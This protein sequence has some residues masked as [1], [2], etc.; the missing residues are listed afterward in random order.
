MSDAERDD[1]G[2]RR[3]RAGAALALAG[4]AARR[5]RH[6]QRDAPAARAEGAA[7]R[8]PGRRDR[9]RPGADQRPLFAHR[10]P[11]IF[12]APVRPT[13]TWRGRPRSSRC[14]ADGMPE[15]SDDF[16]TWTVRIKPGIYFADD[17]AFK[18]KKRELVAAGLRLRASSASPTRRN[19]SPALE[20]AR[21]AGHRRPDASCATQALEARSRFDYDR[22]VEG[23]RAL[24]RYT[25]QLQARAS[26]G[27]ASSTRC[28]DARRLIGAVAREV[29]E[30][31]GDTIDG[32][33]G[34]HRAVLLDAVAAPLADRARAQP[35]T[36]AR[37]VYDAEPA[38]DDAEGQ[39]LAARFKGRRLPMVDRVEI[40]IIEEEQPR[41]L[42]FLNG[43]HDLLRAPAA[44]VRRR[45]RCPTASS[46]RTWPSAA[47][48][49]Q[50]V[51]GA[52]VALTIFNMEDPVVG[53]YTPAQG[54]AAPRDRPG[55]R[56]RTRDRG[57]LRR[58]QAV[59]AQS[60]VPP[61]DVRLRPGAARA[62]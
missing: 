53:G 61:H 30:H 24:D 15:V 20:R 25:L 52:D 11:H 49:L 8:V 46:R 42:A 12:E 13:T 51:A 55:A 40:S 6:R 9:L 27:R 58:G 43:E 19:K 1:H 44:R 2:A 28:A 37:C 45:R 57:A 4:A 31:Y 39:A 32:A 7:L 48:A 29:V 34:R 17:P 14:T 50:R 5:R 18:G 16:R 60:I 38:A 59:P 36:T 41:W 54:R 26:R 62:R 22:E 23:L 47:S 33:P 3:C 10:H 35:A 21:G 56:R